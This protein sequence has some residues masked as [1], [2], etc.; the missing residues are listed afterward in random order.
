MADITPTCAAPPSSVASSAYR[1][2]AGSCDC[3]MHIFGP[4]AQ[5]PL[6]PGRGYTP[7]V[8]TL[9]Q[10]RAVMQALGIERAVIVQ[11]SVYGLDNRATLDAL[12]AGGAA[13]RAIVVPS[14]S[15][16]D[17]ELRDWNDAGVRGIRLNLVNP[18]VL[19]VD[20]AVALAR[21][22]APLGWHLQVQLDLAT[23]DVTPVTALLA[24]VGVPVV[25]DHIGRLA[26]AAPRGPLLAV[27][28][29]GRCWVKL[30]A[31]YR[32]SRQPHPHDD[33]TPLV[34]D[35]L[36]HRPDRLLWATDWPH[37]ELART[38]QAAWFG[39]LLHRWMP[40]PALRQQVCVDNARTLYGF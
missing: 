14:P 10:Y 24:R 27:L 32:L 3:H 21:R 30:S 34:R 7:H 11:P 29:A 18:A 1:L 35:L 26:P 15:I 28:A 23:G 20:D 5:Y 4:Y 40:A 39:E 31:P 19:S 13:F 22:I 17:A 36:D 16:T 25:V 9:D 8:C 6:D 12:R 2:P 38:P 33:L 37:T